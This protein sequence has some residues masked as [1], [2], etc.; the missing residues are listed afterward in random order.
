MIL[1]QAKEVLQIEAEGILGVVDRLDNNFVKMVDLIYACK[2]RVILTGI[3]KSGIVARKIVATLNSTGTPSLF[4]HPVEAMHGDLGMVSADDVVIA[5]SNSGET[6]EL[7]MLIPSIK[8][9]GCPL[10]AFAGQ[11]DSTLGRKSDIVIDVGV[12]REACP[13]GL[14]PT[15]STTALL[16]MGDALAVTLIRKR[17]FNSIDFRRFHPGG[18]LG[19]CLSVKVQEIMLTGKKIPVVSKGQTMRHAIQ[20]INRMQLGATLVVERDNR[21][22]GIITDGDIRRFLMTQERIYDRP[23]EE[24]M[25]KDPKT[26]GPDSLASRALNIMEKHEITILPIVNP[27]RK[28]RGIL[29]LHDILGKGAFKFNGV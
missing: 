1:K 28:I 14:A 6:D 12:E 29:H 27:V 24:V 19:Q 15:A 22:V 23:V 25:T 21:L 26:L 7:N 5:L 18:T 3:G 16:A 4:L 8:R 20:E 10:I 9:I 13:L 17:N 11:V 2:G